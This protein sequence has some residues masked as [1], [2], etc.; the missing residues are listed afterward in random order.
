MLMSCASRA[1][2]SFYIM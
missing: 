1:L 2:V